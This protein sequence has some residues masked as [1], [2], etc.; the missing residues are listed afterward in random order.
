MYHN[1]LLLVL[2]ELQLLIPVLLILLVLLVLV[3]LVLLH[4]SRPLPLI[5]HNG[6]FHL[7]EESDVIFN[8]GVACKVIWQKRLVLGVFTQVS[9]MLH[10]VFDQGSLH[11]YC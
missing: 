8:S 9:R 10:E 1:L 2:L 7:L 5:R 11:P 3:L 4:P 6:S